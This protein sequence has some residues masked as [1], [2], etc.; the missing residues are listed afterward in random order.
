MR[1]LPF[2]VFAI[3]F[4]VFW[5]R[6]SLFAIIC[7]SLPVAYLSLFVLDEYRRA[8]SKRAAVDTRYY[9]GVFGGLALSCVGDGCLTYMDDRTLFL[10]G[11]IFFAL[12]HA[13]YVYAFGLQPFRAAI[14]IPCVAISCY[15]FSYLYEG[16]KAHNMVFLTGLYL[17]IIT[18]MVWRSL[19]RLERDQTLTSV[20]A[21]IG[22]FLFFGSD[23]VLA[24]NKF[25]YLV[26][27]SRLINLTTYFG[28]QLAI[29]LSVV[30]RGKNKKA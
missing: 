7:K 11:L 1:I 21:V 19:V 25:L 20:A 28:G 5:P 4:I 23:V 27:H 12:G 30:G 8:Q 26:P 9:L 29:A 22:A 6:E 16:F 13:V 2:L 15:I 14:F 24:I 3:G 10:A 18:V 17:G